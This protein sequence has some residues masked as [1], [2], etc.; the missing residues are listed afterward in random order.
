[1]AALWQTKKFPLNCNV[2]FINV[3][4]LFGM[5]RVNGFW[6]S[7]LPLLALTLGCGQQQE[8][9]ESND[10]GT[11]SEIRLQNPIGVA[12]KNAPVVISRQQLTAWTGAV[13]E[14]SQPLLTLN[15]QTVPSQADDL[16][17]NGQWDELA[18]VTDLPANGEISLNIVF[19]A[20]ADMPVFPPRT[21]IRIGLKQ[22]DGT[23]ADLGEAVRTPEEMASDARLPYQMEG[24][25][26]ENEQVGFRIYFD[27]RN[28]KDIFGKTAPALALDRTGTGEDYHSLQPWGMDVL[29]VG[30]SLG[31]GSLAV[32]HDGQPF[33]LGK[34]RRAKAL[35]VAQ[36]PVRAILRLTYEG[37]DV[38]GE[39]L[40]VTE[41]IHIWAGKYWCQ[42]KVTLTGFEGEKELVTGVVNLLS[43][44]GIPLD[45]PGMNGVASHGLQS[46]NKDRLGMAV[47]AGSDVFLGS[48][49]LRKTGND[50]TDTYIIRLKA[51]AG[52][53]VGFYFF[54]GWEL[55][56]PAFASQ[57]GFLEYL[58]DEALAISQPPKV[59]LVLRHL[60]WNH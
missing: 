24:P 43:E 47:L 59:S 9:S 5:V 44:V 46:E 53:A 51:K 50:V 56:S 25:A 32:M 6:K 57:E 49:E 60:V 37:W 30:T 7:I 22:S 48:G 40:D 3:K 23:F 52:E 55:S 2:V 27:N 4:L 11:N 41:D 31:A 35:A 36:G 28:G 1:M 26:W 15:G 16:N 54:A 58:Q 12:V 39:L 18:F 13:P 33:R 21:N 45:F 17:G 14:G 38:G 8:S 10:S 20:P 34:T 42:S 19:V 29:K